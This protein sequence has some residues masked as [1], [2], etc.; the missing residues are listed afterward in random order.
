MKKHLTIAGI[1][2]VVLALFTWQYLAQTQSIS[3]QSNIIQDVES[4][5]SENHQGGAEEGNFYNEGSITREDDQEVLSKNKFRTD[6]QNMYPDDINKQKIAYNFAKELEKVLI[7]EKFDEINIDNFLRATDCMSFN[8]L[9]SDIPLI[10]MLV[11]NTDERY[12]K[13][14][15]FNDYESG[16]FFGGDL[17]NLDCTFE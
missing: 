6:I 15:D 1:G 5:I 14:M 8:M 13:Y 16:K 7:V 10:E 3:N 12:K 11:F 9:G 17:E 4:N 2:I